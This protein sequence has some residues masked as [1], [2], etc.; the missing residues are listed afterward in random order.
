[1]TTRGNKGCL[2]FHQCIY[3]D[4]CIVWFKKNDPQIIKQ[5]LSNCL[6][7]YSVMYLARSVLAYHICNDCFLCMKRITQCLEQFFLF[8]LKLC[9]QHYSWK[10]WKSGCYY[11]LPVLHYDPFL[12]TMNN[13]AQMSSF[14]IWSNWDL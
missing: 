5:T 10:G 4:R 14:I 2:C 8:R 11:R 6:I 9:T 12:L 1:M 13:L 7:L 3:L